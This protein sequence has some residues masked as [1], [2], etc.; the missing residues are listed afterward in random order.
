[1]KWI[2]F[3][4]ISSTTGKLQHERAI[5]A[6]SVTTKYDFKNCEICEFFANIRKACQ[7]LIAVFQKMDTPIPFP[8]EKK[9]YES[10]S[11]YFCALLVLWLLVRHWLREVCCYLHSHIPEPPLCYSD[12][13]RKLFRNESAVFE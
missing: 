6:S 9:L 3:Y 12:R 13:P 10:I 5:G 11:I 4:S 8:A 1:M 2:Y 7:F